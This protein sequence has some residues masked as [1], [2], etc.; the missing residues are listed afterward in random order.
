MLLT[1]PSRSYAVTVVERAPALRTGGQQIDLR[2]Q[3]IPIVRRMGLLP[4]IKARC[5]TEEGL[6]LVDSHGGV[7]ALLRKNDT[8]VSRQ[9]LT[10]EYEIMRGELVD[11]LALCNIPRDPGD[12]QPSIAKMYHVPG[13]RMF[14]TRTG[15]QPVTQVALSTMSPSQRLVES[16]PT[17]VEEQKAAWAEA[18]KG[19]GWNTDQLLEGMLNTAD[20][21]YMSESAQGLGSTASLVGSYVLA[22]ELAKHGDDVDTALEGYTAV[23]KPFI[24][25]I[26]KLAPG[27]PRLFYCD[28][29]EG[30]WLL[31]QISGLFTALGIARLLFELLPEAQGG[32]QLP[33]YSGL[34]FDALNR[35]WS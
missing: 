23:M 28:T 31:H 3:G 26:Q 19:A 35:L 4:A 29:Q 5:T 11:V 8:G 22:G 13:R 1:S 27:M 34:K 12:D 15:N 33:D 30:I 6:A 2:A 7:K 18:F 14:A 16:M 17:S 32:W 20:F 24:T 21:F 9:S 10:S 25:E